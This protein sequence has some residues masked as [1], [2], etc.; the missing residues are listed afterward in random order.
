LITFHYIESHQSWEEEGSCGTL[1]NGYMHINPGV[2]K[3]INSAAGDGMNNHISNAQFSPNY[4]VNNYT[5]ANAPDHQVVNMQVNNN[6][7]G[8]S[9]DGEPYT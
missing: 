6:Y 8:S 5:L 1:S 3:R 4:F 9:A 7:N 2:S